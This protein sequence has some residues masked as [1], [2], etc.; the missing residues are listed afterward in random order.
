MGRAILAVVL[1]YL[2]MFVIVFVCFTG[3]YLGLGADGAFEEGTYAP[4]IIWLAMSIVVGFVAAC[5]GGNVCARVA[6]RPRPLYALAVLI[7][8]FG[9]LSA[10]GAMMEGGEPGVRSGDVGNFEAMTKAVMPAWIAILNSIIGAIGVF[11]GG[12]RARRGQT[13]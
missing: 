3:A 8:L 13:S 5:F 7:L 2:T 9:A 6:S 1:G 10:A 11:M 4:S 12:G